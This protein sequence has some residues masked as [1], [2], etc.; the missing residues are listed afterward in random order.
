MG[1]P[2][3]ILRHKMFPHWTGR[4]IAFHVPGSRLL[5]GWSMMANVV[6]VKT[7]RIFDAF[8]LS[9]QRICVTKT[10]LTDTTRRFI[11]LRYSKI[12]EIF[13]LRMW[14]PKWYMEICVVSLDSDLRFPVTIF[15]WQITLRFLDQNQS[16]TVSDA[17]K[18]SWIWYSCF[19]NL[20][21][22]R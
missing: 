14:S 21:C 16:T 2:L 1:T 18:T 17:S 5:L 3:T 12:I 20:V 6:T 9:E 10:S 19:Q 13:S 15:W 8:I 11:P 22:K 7:I 4:L